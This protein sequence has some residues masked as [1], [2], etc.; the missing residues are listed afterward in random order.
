MD[1][2][3]S[4]LDPIATARIED[5]MQEIKSEYTIVIVTHNMQQAARVSDRT[6][7]FTA[8]VNREQRHP[9]RRA[10]RVRPT[11]RRSSRTRPTSGRR[12]T[13][14]AASAERRAT[15]SVTH[16]TVRARGAH[17]SQ[18]EVMG[19]Q[20][21]PE[22]RAHARGARRR[23]TRALAAAA[24]AADDDIDA[25]NVS[26][27]ERC[28]DLLAR[29]NPMAVDLRLVVSVVRV[30]ADARAHRRPGA[31]GRRSWRPSSHCSPQRARASTSCCVMADA[32]RRAVPRRR[33]G[34]GRP[35]T[36]TL[37]DRSS[38]TGS[39]G[40]GPA[41]SSSSPRRC[42]RLDGPD[43][44]AIALRTLDGRARPSTASP[45]TP[46]ILGSR[47]RYLHHRRPAAPRRRGPV[48]ARA[49]AGATWT[50]REVRR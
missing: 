45:T 40:D 30:T 8:E 12:T 48:M 3:C 16:Y 18:V 6:A 5:L 44:A 19:V 50:A 27:T 20:R 23:A 7:F 35:T 22:P 21:R 32:G 46:P 38:P 36:S 11:P 10:R 2:P 15:R 37:A 1:E 42:S 26:L 17:A 41:A 33:C 25:M 31:A 43:A 28:Y 49:P 9:H 24:I 39:R 4:A 13:S 34:P 14:P 29:E 47:I